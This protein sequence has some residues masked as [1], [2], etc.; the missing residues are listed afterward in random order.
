[1]K[2]LVAHKTSRYEQ[3]ILQQRD[4][5]VAAL[6]E[7]RDISVARLRS[8]HD[9]HTASLELVREALTRR[10]LAHDVIARAEVERIEGYDLVIPV[11]GD[12]TVLDL[13]H[14]IPS[15]RVLAINSDPSSS[16][17]YF[18]AGTAKSF[19][20]LLERTLD[21][22]W[23]PT[24]LRRFAVCINDQ[25][26]TPPVLNETLVCHANPAAVSSYIMRVNAHEESHRS[27]GVWIATPAGS[28]AAIRSA[29]GLVMPI[30]ST[31]FQFLV[32][33]PYQSPSHAYRQTKGIHPFG[34]PIELISKMQEGR[35]Y[36]DGPHICLNF[37][38]GDRLTLDFDIP[39]FELYGV[40]DTRR[41]A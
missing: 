28:T 27:S 33:E 22:A 18:C 7:A 23:Q 4:P 13:S 32:R 10:G 8:S 17:G 6:L 2:I 41:N 14:K 12:G 26:R 36:V 34:T 35:I 40:N 19:E 9:A 1:M 24:L 25:E 29:G 15:T 37:R 20:A 16:V 39:P 11:G 30:S 5:G 3:L 31:N 38:I 21:D